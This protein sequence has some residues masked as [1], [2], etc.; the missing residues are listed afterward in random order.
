MV[1]FLAFY[2]GQMKK[3]ELNLEG[4]TNT[5]E[6]FIGNQVTSPWQFNSDFY[7]LPKFSQVIFS[8]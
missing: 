5:L 6:H 4:K 8:F 2:I 1:R 3:N 7:N